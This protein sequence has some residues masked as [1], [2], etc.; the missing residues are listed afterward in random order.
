M[1][2]RN[3][4]QYL[5]SINFSHLYNRKFQ[6]KCASIREILKIIAQIL[7]PLMIGI[8]TLVV[9]LQQHSLNREN[10]KNDYEIAQK[11]RQQQYT[12]NE[13]ER[14]QEITLN[15]IEYLQ[16]LSI[17]DNKQRDLVFNNYIRDLTNLLLNNNYIL[18]RHILN[19]IVRPM[20]LTVLRQLD[21]IRKVLLIK[22]LY[23][24]KM[25]RTDSESNRIDLTNA[26]LNGIQFKQIQLKN[27]S[28]VGASIINASFISTNLIM[29]DFQQA[30]LTN[31]LFLNSDLSQG[32]FYRTRLKYVQ[33][34]NSILMDCDLSLSDL[35]DSTIT[36]EQIRLSS[37]FNMA[38][39]PNGSLG[40]NRNLIEQCSLNHWKINRR[41]SINLTKECFFIGLKNNITM[42]YSIPLYSFKR[43]IEK[44][45]ALLLFY[46]QAK[47]N[48]QENIKIDFSYSD[49]YSSEEIYRGKNKN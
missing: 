35:T 22:F 1:S 47:I 33:F 29:S 32:N 49:E 40:L 24:S 17:A 20:T 42:I 5:N 34:S 39:M 3:Y 48:N 19:I 14:K 31:S 7:L 10:R 23:E 25:L 4:T 36:D 8:F 2:A 16:D 6:L 30:D 38:K 9:A 41:K 43:L 27:L 11:H 44:Q 12:I 15:Q 45:Q 37:S 13:Q 28:L 26:D 21:P 18:N 46:F